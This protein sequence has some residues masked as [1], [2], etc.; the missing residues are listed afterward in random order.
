MSFLDFLK[1][2]LDT[3]PIMFGICAFLLFA[4][5]CSLLSNLFSKGGSEDE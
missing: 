2:W 4:G 5:I 3:H 1:Y